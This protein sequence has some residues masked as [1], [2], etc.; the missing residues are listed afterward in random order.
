[1]NKAPPSSTRL[2]SLMG[3][4]AGK[5]GVTRQKARK[6]LAALGISAVASLTRALL[7]SGSR[8][9]RWEA[10]KTLGAIADAGTMP[11]LVQALEDRDADVRWLAAEALRRFKKAAWP[12]LLR[13]V[14]ASGPDSVSL[15]QGAHHVL[16][17]QKATGFNELLATLRRALES[18]AGQEAAPSAAYDVL[19]RMKARS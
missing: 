10:A 19:E 18:N 13:A 12:L 16:R 14:I 15:R 7:N 17:N 1:M 2:E 6:L 11:A 8:Q 9:L 5:D 3:M 4:L